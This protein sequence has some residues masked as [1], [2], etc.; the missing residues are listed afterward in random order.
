MNGAGFF[1]IFVSE[2]TLF[3]KLGQ[4]VRLSINKA[5]VFTT[6]FLKLKSMGK[7]HIAPFWIDQSEFRLLSGGRQYLIDHYRDFI[8]CKV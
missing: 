6:L 8:V 3:Y 2:D 4:V 1:L 5:N 7:S